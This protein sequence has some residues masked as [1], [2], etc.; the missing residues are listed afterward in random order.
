MKTIVWFRKD[1]RYQANPALDRAAKLGLEIIP[2]F[3][4]S[5]KEESFELGPYQLDIGAASKLWLHY[6]LKAMPELII[7]RGNSQAELEKLI[8]ET[9]AAHLFWNRRYEPHIIKRDT[10]IKEALS[11]KIQVETFNS[12]LLTEPWE[13]ETQSGSPYKVFTPFYKKIQGLY[14]DEKFTKHKLNKP[15]LKSLKPEDLDLLPK[16]NWHKSIVDFWNLGSNKNPLDKFKAENYSQ[17]RNSLD[18]DGTSLIAPYLAWGQI[19]PKEVWQLYQ[20][21]PAAEPFIRQLAWRD[22]AYH[23]LYHFPQSVTEPL[24]AKFKK[25]PWQDSD[26][27][28]ARWT[29]GKTGFDV[30]DAAMNQLWQTGWMHNRA[31]MVVASFLT[32]DL[33]VHWHHGAA[34]FWDTLLDADLAN[35]TMGWQWVAGCGADAAPYFRIFNPESQSQRFD[36]SGNYKSQWL[37][38]KSEPLIDHKFARER[39]LDIYGQLKT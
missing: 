32:K 19:S 31:R 27:D 8:E 37:E 10:K 20:D 17:L 26:E 6:A 21:K 29:Q 36:P 2:V 35:N 15:K 11:K 14:F 3:I 16:I 4:Y 39:A 13:V 24:N 38:H 28:L 18:Q 33:L 30:V 12:A 1:L 9:G 23:L 34:W 22:F 7:R 5:P 25:F